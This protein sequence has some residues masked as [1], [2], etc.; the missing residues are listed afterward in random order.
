MEQLEGK[1]AV[2]T[3]GASGIGRGIALALAKEGAL[4]VIADIE[5][6]PAQAVAEEIRADGGRAI[7]V[8]TDVA[9]RDSLR[10]LAVK[11]Y[12]AFGAVHVLCNN[13]GVFV[14][15][16]VME[17]PPEEW[18]WMWAVNVMGVVE[19]VRAFLPRMRAQG[20]EGHIVNTSSI[21]GLYPTPNQGAYCASKY[22]VV[23]ISER[24][25]VELAPDGIGV[26]VLCPS[27]VRTR[28]TES[29][30]NRHREFGGPVETAPLVSGSNP[31]AIEP[32][33]AAALVV[34][35]IRDNRLYIH[36]HLEW[37]QR[38]RERFD[39][40]FDDFRAIES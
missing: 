2:V 3:G 18:A 32:A 6:T 30:R 23:A 34:R 16:Q 36:T 37:K 40:I 12:E 10:A 14:G 20:T 35:G 25:R 26:S 29:R 22:A 39:A 17:T 38:F 15:G 28:I 31:T 21:S 4:L 13:A 8:K 19:G 27:G 24:L 11:A 33:E 7:A 5:E 1:V 9:D